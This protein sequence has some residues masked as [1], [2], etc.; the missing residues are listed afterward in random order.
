MTEPNNAI[1]MI[2]ENPL[3]DK[4][5]EIARLWVTDQGP[6]TAFI[7]AGSMSDPGQFG[8]LLADT[9]H[10]GAIAYAK[11]HG[12]SEAEARDRIWAALV[13]GRPGSAAGGGTAGAGPGSVQRLSC[14]KTSSSEPCSPVP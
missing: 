10:Y 7:N 12:M 2:P 6:S 1:R 14:G 8:T 11:L 13:A 4:S 9:A 5:Y 3:T